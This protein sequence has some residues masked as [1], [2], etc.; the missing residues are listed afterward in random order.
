MKQSITGYASNL[1]T[2]MRV[3]VPQVRFLA[4][5]LFLRMN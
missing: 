1:I 3:E 2:R 4:Q 5:Q